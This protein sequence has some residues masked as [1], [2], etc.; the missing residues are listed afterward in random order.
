MAQSKDIAT[1]LQETLTK[2]GLLV[3]IRPISKNVE[4]NDNYYEV[5]V[6][7]SEVEEAHG[8]I[9]ETGY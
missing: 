7:E 5:L 4:N 8:I 9:I 2:E 1:K 3:K 6:P